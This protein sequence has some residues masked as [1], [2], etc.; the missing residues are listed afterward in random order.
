M[1]LFTRF[2]LC[3]LA[4][5]M[6]LV[7]FTACSGSDNGADT[8]TDY[9]DDGANDPEDETTEPETEL[10]IVIVPSPSL[11]SEDEVEEIGIHVGNTIVA[12]EGSFGGGSVYDGTN[13]SGRPLWKTSAAE[14][15]P[16]DP[17]V[18]I[19]E[20]FPTVVMTPGAE[21][22]VVNNGGYQFSAI[23]YMD[24]ATGESCGADTPTAVG[25]YLCHITVTNE[26]PGA[27]DPL[28]ELGDQ[29]GTWNYFVVV[30]VE[31]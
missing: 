18:N 24:Y 6:I 13:S 23:N 19:P 5:S 17:G 21:I 25:V 29:F 12:C 26:R 10:T 16:I 8:T 4:L 11:S 3:L 20:G 1:K 15:W 27:A 28:P 7:P 30:S 14:L 9:R 22:A 31:E 2:L